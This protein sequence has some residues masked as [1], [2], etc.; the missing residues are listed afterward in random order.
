VAD[1]QTQAASLPTILAGLPEDWQTASLADLFNIQQGK[2]LSPA[3]RAGK[4]PRPFLRTGNVLW[5]RIDLSSVDSMDFSEEEATRLA[6]RPGDLLICEG[7]DIGRSAIWSGQLEVC[8]YQNHLHRLRP[9]GTNVE[10]YFYMFWMQAALLILGL[11]HGEGNRTTIPNL[12]KARLGG[13][14]V[15]LPSLPEQRRIVDVLRTVQQ[16]Q[17][18]TEAVIA[19]TR[20]LKQSLMR[21][22][23]TYGPVPVEEADRVPLKE[24]E[25]GLLPEHWSLVQLGS[26]CESLQYGTS[27]KCI[28]GSE[29]TPVL[30]IPNVIGQEI[31]ASDLKFIEWNE[32]K[33]RNLRLRVGDLLFVRTNGR[34]EYTGRCAI[35]RGIPGNA[36]FASY[37]IRARLSDRCL[38]DFLRLYASSPT[39]QSYLSGRASNAADGKYNIN[40]QTIR[41]VVMPLPPLHEQRAIVNAIM[42]AE[43]KLAAERDRATVLDSLFRSLLENVMTGRLRVPEAEAAVA[44][45]GVG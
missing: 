32:N 2:A 44:A 7:G 25:I 18:T 16:A 19:A 27:E 17:E 3:G 23:F 30:R 43:A 26:L 31:D 20:A 8:C 45:A 35:F 6:L 36:L 9:K 39:G 29:A 42:A 22:L 1:S 4:A 11:Y 13:Y 15:P 41:S 24:T 40:T 12:S 38:P 37:L 14:A 21:H 28:A 10:P 33:H 5:G 34:R